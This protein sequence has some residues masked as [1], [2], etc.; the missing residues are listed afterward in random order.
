[1]K[2]RDEGGGM[3]DEGKGERYL[4]TRLRRWAAFRDWLVMTWPA[5][6]L[7]AL[8]SPIQARQTRIIF[9]R[10][11]ELSDAEAD[12]LMGFND[13]EAKSRPD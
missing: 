8:I 2:P 10:I 5:D 1:V 6:L 13:A 9:Q 7:V 3:R 4:S 12:A 11:F